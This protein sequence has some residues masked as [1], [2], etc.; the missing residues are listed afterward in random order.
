MLIMENYKTKWFV[1]NL[2]KCYSLADVMSSQLVLKLCKKSR[3]EPK[4]SAGLF[5]G[6]LSPLFLFSP[7]VDQGGNAEQSP[8]HCCVGG[9][10]WY[11]RSKFG[12][13][14][15]PGHIESHLE[16]PH[17]ESVQTLHQIGC[18]CSH[19]HLTGFASDWIRTGA[20]AVA[21]KIGCFDEIAVHPDAHGV[22]GTEC[23]AAGV[24]LMRQDEGLG[25]G[26]TRS[27]T[28]RIRKGVSLPVS[29]VVERRYPLGTRNGAPKWVGRHQKSVAGAGN[30]T[31]VTR[32]KTHKHRRRL[33]RWH[34]QC[35]KNNQNQQ[36]LH[37]FLL[38]PLG[39]LV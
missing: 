24:D 4:L 39:S 34:E 26:V 9:W 12:R 6:I 36:N 25:E 30:G 11:C 20:G 17:F 5:V 22:I 15:G 21:N 8:A 32:A 27:Y 18:K 33:C 35:E 10:L 29:C 28:I 14:G 38:F 19:E 37:F 3:R 7:P 13:P 1:L 31:P 23:A 16:H 2:K